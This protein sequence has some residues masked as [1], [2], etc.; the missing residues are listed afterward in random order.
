MRLRKRCGVATVC[1]AAMISCGDNADGPA[2]REI[3]PRGGAS[4][5]LPVLATVPEF[6]LTDQT[7]NRFGTA[8]LSGDVWVANFIFTRC[9]LSCPMQTAK[10]AALKEKL[11]GLDRWDAIS[12]VS[13]SVDPEYDTP[14]VLQAY[15][16]PYGVDPAHWRFLTGDR[17]EIWQLSKQG[18]KLPVEEQQ[19]EV[20]LPLFHSSMLVLVDRRRQIRGFYDGLGDDDLTRVYEDL[21]MIADEG[22]A[23]R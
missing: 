3:K 13:I 20:G 10:L 23:D 19:M 15:G 5:P 9:V 22:L 7:G 18:F 14:A 2:G 6:V 11:N 12:L 21:N 1:L 16:E 17:G 4:E 8:Q